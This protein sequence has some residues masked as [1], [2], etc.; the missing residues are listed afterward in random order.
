M[1][2]GKRVDEAGSRQEKRQYGEYRHEVDLKIEF[3][4]DHF[5]CLWRRFRGSLEQTPARFKSPPAKIFSPG[6]QWISAFVS[7]EGGHSWA[8]GEAL[9]RGAPASQDGVFGL[10]PH[11]CVHLAHMLLPAHDSFA[12]A[13]V[14]GLG[15]VLDHGEKVAGVA[16]PSSVGSSFGAGP[17][18]TRELRPFGFNVRYARNALLHSPAR[19]PDL[20]FALGQWLWVMSGADDLETIAYYNSLGRLFSDDG[21]R[22]RGA[23]GP[24][25]GGGALASAV[26]LLRQD[27]ATRRAIIYLADPSGSRARTRDH[28]CA[29]S[30]QFLVR[31]NRLEA[32][33]T[34]RSQSALMV[35]PY[36]AALF[37]TIQ[38]WV[39]ALLG[40]E[41][42]SHTWVAN[43]FHVYEDEISLAREVLAKPVRSVTLPPV[44]DSE[45]SLRGLLH[46][47][48]RLRRATER[49]DRVEVAECIEIGPPLADDL[50]SATEAVLLAHAGRRLADPVLW[51]GALAKLPPGWGDCLRAPETLL[52]RQGK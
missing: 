45:P 2:A 5:A 11:T 20:G 12:E 19:Q 42:G 41:A 40:I 51:Q 6:H 27:P 13:Y 46:F 21:R 17:R 39:A 31:G 43:S 9:N 33:T 7:R 48:R 52:E 16:D 36:D 44:R 29:I 24:R 37:M 22:L 35:L 14:A 18:P 28:S 4:L 23:F 26:A 30:L 15:D 25:V 47:E 8:P 38:V 3:D 32:I 1:L 50:E 34:M 10:T 49:G